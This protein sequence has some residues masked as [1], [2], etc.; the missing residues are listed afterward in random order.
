V[1]DVREGEWWGRVPR[2]PAT[3]QD[4][5]SNTVLFTEKLAIPTGDLWSSTPWGGNSWFEWAPRVAG[6]VSGPGS[7]FISQPT[8]QYCQSTL[9]GAWHGG[10]WSICGLTA[11]SPHSNG[12]NVALADGSVRFVSAGVSGNSWWAAFTPASGETLGNDW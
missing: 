8:K 6:D 12:I 1:F 3:L 9:V 5:T 7:K 4:G 2:Y 10:S 11:T